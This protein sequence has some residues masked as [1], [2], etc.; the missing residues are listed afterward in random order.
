M[1]TKYIELND[2]AKRFGLCSKTIKKW[3]SNPR[4]G[5]PAPVE[6]ARRKYFDIEAIEAWEAAN[7]KQATK[8]A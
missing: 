6:I 5:M 1:A 2:L 7:T 8:A 3:A 4:L